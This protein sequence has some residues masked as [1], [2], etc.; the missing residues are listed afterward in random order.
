MQPEGYFE[1]YE[2][3]EM[4]PILPDFVATSLLDIDFAQLHQK[5]GAQHV[6]LDVDQTLRP[7]RGTV[8]AKEFIDHLNS[9]RDSG[10]IESI[11]LVTNNRRDLSAFAK[12]LQARVFQPTKGVHKPHPEFFNRVLREL[13]IISAMAVMV[14][15]KLRPDIAGANRVGIYTV[16]VQPLG[17]DFLYDRLLLTRLRERIALR[18]HKRK[19]KP[20][21]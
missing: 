2:K 1:G 19:Q 21:D 18:R 17:K 13:G 4:P 14:G 3:S 11:S 9:F 16:W 12:P 20:N 6:F 5:T 8:L 15:D 10:D 7:V